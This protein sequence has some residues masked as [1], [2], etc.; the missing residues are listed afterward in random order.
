MAKA[1][2]KRVK[3]ITINGVL[4]IGENGA[5]TVETEDSVYPLQELVK[6][7]DK[8]VVTIAVSVQEEE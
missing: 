8:E 6:E 5:M 2:I 7:F 3:R 1:S 4:E